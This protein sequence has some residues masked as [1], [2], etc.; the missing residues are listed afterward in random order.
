MLGKLRSSSLDNFILTDKNKQSIAGRYIEIYPA[1][2]RVFLK[3]YLI[4]S[5]TWYIFI[6]T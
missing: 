4:L 2:V 1:N 6:K 3:L 5:L